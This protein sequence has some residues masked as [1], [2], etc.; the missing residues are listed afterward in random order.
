MILPLVFYYL[1][2]LASD[3]RLMG[4]HVNTRFQTR[5]TAW[6]SIL[7]VAASVSTVGALIFRW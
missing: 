5:F 6:A 1:I 3:P 4:A 7:I 2:R